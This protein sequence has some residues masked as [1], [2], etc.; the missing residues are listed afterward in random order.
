MKASLI[1]NE[2]NE[3]DTV[4]LLKFWEDRDIEKVGDHLIGLAIDTYKDDKMDEDRFIMDESAY[5]SIW[6]TIEDALALRSFLDV[7]IKTDEKS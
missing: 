3:N 4:T 1:F 2:R 6:L 5:R 7:V